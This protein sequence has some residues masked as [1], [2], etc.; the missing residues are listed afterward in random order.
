LPQQPQHHSFHHPPLLGWPPFP[1]TTFPPLQVSK[2]HHQEME[3]TK[4]AKLAQEATLRDE[5]LAMRVATEVARALNL[6]V[7]TK[8]L[9]IVLPLCTRDHLLV[10]YAY[11]EHEMLA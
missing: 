8:P 6:S 5:S 11:V 2:R 1:R 9:L 7:R 10:H 3:D 4:K